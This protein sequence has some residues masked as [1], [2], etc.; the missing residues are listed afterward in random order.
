M[1]KQNTYNH[2][3]VNYKTEEVDGPPLDYSFK[4]IRVL[5]GTPSNM[6]ISSPSILPKPSPYKHRKMQ[7]HWSLS[8]SSLPRKIWAIIQER[9]S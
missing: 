2:K 6:Q 8:G 5:A 9:R 3:E 4:N 7:S 1:M